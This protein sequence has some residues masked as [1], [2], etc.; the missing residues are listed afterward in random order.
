MNAFTK[1][2]SNVIANSSS[3]SKLY[4]SISQTVAVCLGTHSWTGLPSIISYVC[5]AL[6]YLVPNQSVVKVAQ[7][8][9]PSAEDIAAAIVKLMQKLGPA[10]TSAPAPATTPGST[11]APFPGVAS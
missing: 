7:Q 3:L 8:I 11:I 6:V 2:L 10:P 4:V 5:N 9:A 1:W